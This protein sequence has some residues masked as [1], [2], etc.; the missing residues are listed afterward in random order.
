MKFVLYL[1]FCCFLMTACNKRSGNESSE[2]NNPDAQSWFEEG[3]W[4][5]GWKIQADESLDIVEFSSRYSANPERWQRAFEFL[6]NTDLASIEPGRYELEGDKLFVL[7]Q[8]FESK[9]EMDVKF[10]AHKKYADIHYVVRGQEKIGW[11]PIAT[12]QVLDPYDESKDIAFFSSE[13]GKYRLSNSETFFIFF[14]DDM[15]RPGVRVSGPE[16]VKKIVIKVAL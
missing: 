7:A 9:D 2:G 12:A 8:E 16:Q 10:E 14:P 6:A 11:A 15:H 4:R 5:G 1:F 3:A 13:E